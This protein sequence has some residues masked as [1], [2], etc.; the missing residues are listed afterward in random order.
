MQNRS[1]VMVLI[2]TIITLGIY[3]LVWFVTTKNEMKI[4]GAEIPTAWLIIIPI[5][6]YIW[7]W[8]FSQG[9][10]LVTDKGMSTG[11]A[12]LWMFFLGAIG[13]AIVQSELNKIAI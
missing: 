2:L 10:E 9:I 7:Y 3:G 6:N 12:F 8:K 5:V 13:M 11:T 4:K 1:P